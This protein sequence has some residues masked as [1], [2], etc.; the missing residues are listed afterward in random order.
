MSQSA[1]EHL[2]FTKIEMKH[3]N[4]MLEYFLLVVDRVKPNFN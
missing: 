1:H 4:E 2:I 3:P